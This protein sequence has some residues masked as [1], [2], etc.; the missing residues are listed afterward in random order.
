[1][2]KTQVVTSYLRFWM[3]GSLWVSSPTRT[4]T[5][6][7]KSTKLSFSSR[8]TQTRRNGRNILNLRITTDIPRLFWMAVYGADINRRR[9]DFLC[10]RVHTFPAL[11]SPFFR[12][13]VLSALPTNLSRKRN[14]LPVLSTA[15]QRNCPR[16]TLIS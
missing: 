14:I 15:E 9:M 7:S 3:K 11:R 8:F 6:N 5:L 2:T 10:G 1:M 16:R 4:M 13:I 12:G